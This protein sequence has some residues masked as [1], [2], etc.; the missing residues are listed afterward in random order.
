MLGI[1]ISLF[2][3]FPVTWYVSLALIGF[4]T[5]LSFLGRR[6]RA[7]GEADLNSLSWIFLGLGIISLVKL[8]IFLIIFFVITCFYLILKVYVF[9]NKKSIP[10][11]P[12]IL[13]VY[14][15]GLWFLRLF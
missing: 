1:T 6:I 11:Y 9:K 14:V 13:V 4:V 3:H 8:A 15:F 10:F 5:L 2:S 12:I 7:F